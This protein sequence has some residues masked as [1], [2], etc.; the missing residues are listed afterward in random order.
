MTSKDNRG[1]TLAL[2]GIL[3]VVAIGAQV[4][5]EHER[6][7]ARA[8]E[9][10]AQVARA[11]ALA[12]R[13]ESG[14]AV[15]DQ[16]VRDAHTGPL[17]PELL[18]EA[19]FMRRVGAL[20]EGYKQA[21]L[22]IEPEKSMKPETLASAEGRAEARRKQAAWMAAL[23]SYDTQ[24]RAAMDEARPALQAAVASLGPET[25][26]GV[27]RVFD[28]SRTQLTDFLT[29]FGESQRATST[30]IVAVLDLIDANPR[31][32][33][34][35]KDPQPHLGFRSGADLEVYRTSMQAIRAAAGR[36]E[37]AV[38]SADKAAAAWSARRTTSLESQQ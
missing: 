8:E 11:V 25:S 21:V 12:T 22:Q 27:L 36:E 15:S 14:Q 6:A 5:R 7:L 10:K 24:A 26:S 16:E 13:L 23:D 32:V 38:D 34:L 29:R 37:A 3:V 17:E 35:L 19:S 2:A 31:G 30:A 1:R 28:Q 4:F 20:G 33:V 9:T 18:V